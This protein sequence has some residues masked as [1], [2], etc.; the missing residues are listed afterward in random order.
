MMQ[1]LVD[2]ETGLV[3]EDP[4]GDEYEEEIIEENNGG[5]EDE[6]E[7]D[8]SN[9][10]ASN[11]A[12]VPP[13]QVWRPGIDKIPEG[14]EL[15]YD[16]SAYIMYH[17]L[18]T[19]WSCLSFDVVRDSLGENRQRFP[20]SM[21]LVTGSQ[22]DR[23]EENKIT[24]LQ[25]KDLYKTYE[26]D[27][28][29]EESN[30]DE[31]EESEDDE[32]LDEDPSI[33]HVNVNH[34]GGVNRIRNL[35]QRSGVVASM[36]DTSQ[37]HIYDLS[38]TYNSMVNNTVRAPAPTNPLFTFTGHR[39]EGFALDWSPVT[40]G[41]LLT[42]DCAGKIHLWNPQ[43]G[44]SWLVEPTA[45]TGHKSSV[46]DL[47]WSPTEATVFASASSDKTVKIWDTRDKSKPQISFDAHSE[48]V[49]VISWNHNA[50][51]WLASGSDDGSFKVWDLRFRRGMTPLANFTFH[52]GPITSI[53]WASHDESMIAVSSADNQISIW[54]LSVESESSSDPIFEDYPAQ[55]LFL[56]L[57][58]MNVKELHF[59]PQ[60]PGTLISTAED[61]FDIFKPAI[62][63]SS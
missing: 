19:E 32:N 24:L 63:V 22:A 7:G 11:N 41:R 52:K 6:E 17:S 46:E 31:Y 16:P 38:D 47:Q 57:G 58:Q 42:G 39:E 43:G 4:Y 23:P 30:E 18:R 37:V 29:D 25:L 51:F 3:F 9:V 21:Y 36:A 5:D 48:D 54:D 40:A 26:Q 56:H 44:A 35:P 62:T 28:S 49:N 60:I 59:H 50:S 34:Y 55:L 12:P 27:D 15:D 13:K 14:E 45:F 8:E 53:E 20:L 61:S 33:E 10:E 1:E 2:E